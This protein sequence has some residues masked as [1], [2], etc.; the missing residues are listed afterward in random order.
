MA[1][2][3]DGETK[4]WQEKRM[5]REKG[6]KGWQERMDDEREWMTREKG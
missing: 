3:K 1:R 6:Q 4:G 2:E 5:T